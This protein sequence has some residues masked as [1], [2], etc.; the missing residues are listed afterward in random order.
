[1]D[2][3]SL[4][5]HIQHVAI[6]SVKPL[7]RSRHLSSIKWVSSGA[8]HLM[9]ETRCAY[10]FI[11]KTNITITSMHNNKVL[12][13]HLLVLAEVRHIREVYIQI[14]K[15]HE[16]VMHY[17]SIVYYIVVISAAEFGRIGSRKTPNSALR[18]WCK[19]NTLRGTCFILALSAAH[20]KK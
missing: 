8:N 2:K 9:V 13:L 3:E 14:F 20:L 15:P 1:M 6:C 19:Y 5:C 4:D 18:V 12:C 7:L 16:N 17:N 11:Y 10:V